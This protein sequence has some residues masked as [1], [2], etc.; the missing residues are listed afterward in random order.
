MLSLRATSP[1]L[2]QAC[3]GGLGATSQ[4]LSEAT[5]REACLPLRAFVCHGVKESTRQKGAMQ[6]CEQQG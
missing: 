1:R 4:H 5:S 3:V 2:L 6:L